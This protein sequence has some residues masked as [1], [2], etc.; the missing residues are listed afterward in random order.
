MAPSRE[1]KEHL[2]N[3]Y[4]AAKAWGIS[5]EEIKPVL[6]NL[7]QAVGGRWEDI[8][9][10]DYKIVVET[11]FESNRKGDDEHIDQKLRKRRHLADEE[12]QASPGSGSSSELSLRHSSGNGN[13]RPTCH[14]ASGDGS[15][16]RERASAS[17][18]PCSDHMNYFKKPKDKVSTDDA[19]FSA[20]RTSVRRPGSVNGGARIQR[21]I[22]REDKKPPKYISD[23]TKS[24]EKVAISLIDE[25][26]S[27]SLPRFNYIPQNIIYENAHLNISMSRI[28]DEDCCLDCLGDC[29][30][31]PLPCACAHETGGEFVYTPEGLLKD[32]FLSKR[33]DTEKQEYIYCQDCPSERNK[34]E[35]MPERCKGHWVRKFIKECWRKCGCDMRC[36]NRVVQRG[37]ACKLQVF[38]TKGK[39][40]GVRTLE[41]LEKGSF[42]CEYVGEILTNNELYY[43]NMKSKGNGRHTYPVTL[44]G[45]WGSE[46]GLK[47]EDALCLDATL[48]GNVARF[49]NHRC[50]DGNLVDIPVQVETPDRH[51][52]HVAF[53]TTRKVD[54]F[55]ELTWD[56]GLDFEEVHLIEAFQCICGSQYC[57][58]KNPKGKKVEKL[59]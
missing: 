34:N 48:H 26:G 59:G 55:E 15:V 40:W 49:I 28:A 31:P 13:D 24:T 42:V 12:D 17:A 16:H 37:I 27:E 23:I 56:Y 35:A 9:P 19:T 14:L 8:E 18:V 57:R 5:K 52:Y 3:A 22:T 7:F 1:T 33:M 11:Y 47:D 44:D 6:R 32:D 25:V 53:F 46:Q 29:L 38:H 10:D 41:V 36:G 50:F 2:A 43:R 39:G 51:Y 54:A 30:S 58:G 20:E 4:K 45:D 21:P